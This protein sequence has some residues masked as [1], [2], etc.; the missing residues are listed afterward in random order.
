L[1]V[2]I[3]GEFEGELEGEEEGL[4]EDGSFNKVHWKFP[5]ILFYR[6]RIFGGFIHCTE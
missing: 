2:P 1:K 5:R 6:Q 4:G 3:I